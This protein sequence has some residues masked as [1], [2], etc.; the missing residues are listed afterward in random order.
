MRLHINKFDSLIILVIVSFFMISYFKKANLTQARKT[1]PT[2][3]GRVVATEIIKE[4]YFPLG[5]FGLK[6]RAQVTYSYDIGGI[7]YT[8]DIKT[9][10]MSSSDVQEFVNGYNTNVYVNVNYNPENSS[11]TN[12]G[13]VNGYDNF[14]CNLPIFMFVSFGDSNIFFWD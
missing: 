7:K 3:E 1:W 13:H 4:E 12:L 11:E 5:Y 6:W 2:V 9:C 8:D 10:F 14:L